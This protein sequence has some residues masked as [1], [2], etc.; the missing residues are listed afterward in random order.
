MIVEVHEGVHGSAG[1]GGRFNDRY[2]K[3]QSKPCGSTRGRVVL[4]GD[5]PQLENTCPFLDSKIH[6]NQLSMK[7]SVLFPLRTT[8]Q[9]V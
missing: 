4:I 2:A 7:R 3:V 9:N 6:R 5:S 1:D 8:P